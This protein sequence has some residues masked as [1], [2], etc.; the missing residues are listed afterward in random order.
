VKA[1]ARR[2]LLDDDR[3]ILR[4]FGRRALRIRRRLGGVGNHGRPQYRAC[5]VH[6]AQLAV[7]LGH[8]RLTVVEFGVANG[9][10]LMALER[11]ASDAE[12]YWPVAIDVVG[13][14]LGS[15]LPASTDHRD[16]PWHWTGGD[17]PMNEARLAGALD[18]AELVLGD[19]S[20]TLP[21]FMDQPDRLRHSPVGAVLFDLDYYTSTAVAL[22]LLEGAAEN[23]LPRV[24][25]YFD[26][27]GRTNEHIGEWLAISEF[28]SRHT[29]RKIAFRFDRIGD[30]TMRQ[31]LEFHHFSHPDYCRNPRRDAIRHVAP[32]N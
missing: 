14:D 10:G 11:V 6:G 27:L 26:D 31:V 9:S 32:L 25:T 5:V 12:R 19:I 28:N 2:Y 16:L 21:A 15:G 29:Q 23:H 17:F 4:T 13:F 24:W 3:P 30:P 20:E 7:S 8:A 18:R 22:R 1:I